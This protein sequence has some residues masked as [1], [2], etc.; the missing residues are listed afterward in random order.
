MSKPKKYKKKP[1]AIEAL[2]LTW[3]NW[4]D[5]CDFCKGYTIVDAI[6]EKEEMQITIA[7][8]E[9]EMLAKQFDYIVKGTE[10]EVYPVKKEIFEKI[11][12]EVDD[13]RN[14][15]DGKA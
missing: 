2:Q 8:L 1:I 13:E 7:T 9:G 12:E 6:I 4:V 15:K 14:G 10:G 11:Y 3:E 5:M